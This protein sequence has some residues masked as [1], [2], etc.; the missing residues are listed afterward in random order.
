[1]FAPT[2]NHDPSNMCPRHGLTN[3]SRLKLAEDIEAPQYGGGLSGPP[4]KDW[5]FNHHCKFISQL[6]PYGKNSN[7]VNWEEMQENRLTHWG[8]NRGVL[9]SCFHL[10]IQALQILWREQRN[11]QGKSKMD[12]SYM[13]SRCSLAWALVCSETCFSFIWVLQLPLTSGDWE[14]T[15]QPAAQ[16]SRTDTRISHGH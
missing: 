2:I 10:G 1:M 11:Q 5:Y 14:G 7:S 3:H 15:P 4:Y 6:S 13:Q 16:S 9:F 12:N 8:P